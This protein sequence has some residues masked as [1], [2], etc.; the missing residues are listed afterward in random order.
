MKL[1][2]S[3][4]KFQ[5]KNPWTLSLRT[6]NR[7]LCFVLPPEEHEVLISNLSYSQEE[8]NNGEPVFWEEECSI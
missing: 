3:R 5:V 7:F 1:Q 2:V 4:C 8:G 6:L